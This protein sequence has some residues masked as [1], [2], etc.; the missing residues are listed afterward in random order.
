MRLIDADKLEYKCN[1]SYCACCAAKDECDNCS[2]YV[3][4]K[5]QINNAPTIKKK[6]GTLLNVTMNDVE[7]VINSLS[8]LISVVASEEAEEIGLST[9]LELFKKLR[10]ESEVI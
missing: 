9:T 3:V 6:T 5:K 8:Y 2:C 7:N 10:D 4:T 1:F